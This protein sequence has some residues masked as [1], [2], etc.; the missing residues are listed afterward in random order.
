MSLFALFHSSLITD[1]NVSQSTVLRK[2]FSDSRSSAHTL[3]YSHDA[4][5]SSD[6]DDDDGSKSDGV[7]SL[8]SSS[9]SSHS[10]SGAFFSCMHKFLK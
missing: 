5:T 6:N 1:C 10:S 2:G 8:S 4:D 3:L 7:S 9:D